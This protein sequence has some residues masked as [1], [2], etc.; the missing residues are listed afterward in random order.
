MRLEKGIEDSLSR[1]RGKVKW[2]ENFQILMG[3]G[4]SLIGLF[5]GT[6][7][8][9]PHTKKKD[10]VTNTDPMSGGELCQKDSSDL[11]YNEKKES[12][13]EGDQDNTDD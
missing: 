3:L 9:S 2:D 5:I 7:T 10:L 8:L 4:V 6:D 12:P 11:V 13:R 1:L